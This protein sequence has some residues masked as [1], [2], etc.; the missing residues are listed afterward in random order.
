MNLLSNPS[1]GFL[2]TRKL[3]ESKFVG[4]TAQYN[5]IVRM[6]PTRGPTYLHKDKQQSNDLTTPDPPPPLQVACPFFFIFSHVDEIG[7]QLNT[8][9]NCKIQDQ[10][11]GEPQKATKGGSFP[12]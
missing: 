8:N 3:F 11:K 10:S 1:F 2:P 6:R 7:Q 12:L 9:T 4:F 5:T